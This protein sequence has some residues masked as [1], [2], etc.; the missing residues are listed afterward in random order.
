MPG[1]IKDALKTIFKGH[2]LRL[3]G[4]IVEGLHEGFANEL[5]E[6]GGPAKFLAGFVKASPINVGVKIINSVNDTVGSAVGEGVGE[7][8]ETISRIGSKPGL[9]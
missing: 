8:I 3:I 1:E 2:P 4:G 6:I 5:D 7:A 9:R